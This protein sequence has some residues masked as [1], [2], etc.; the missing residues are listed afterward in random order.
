MDHRRGR[1]G[2]AAYEAIA[3][4]TVKSAQ[5]AVVEQLARGRR[6]RR[7]TAADHPPGQVLRAGRPTARDRHEPPVVHPQRRAAVRGRRRRPARRRCCAGPRSSTG[8]RRTCGPLRELGRGPQRRLARVAPTL[9]RRAVP[10]LVP[11]RRPTARST[12]TTRSCADESSCPSIRRPPRRPASTRPARPARR[13]RRRPRHHGH[14]GHLVADPADRHRLGRGRRPVRQDLPDGPAP[15][16]PRHH[17]HVAV[18]HRAALALE[19]DS[20]PW[21]NAALSGWI[22]DPDRKKMSKSKGN[23]VTPGAPHRAVRRRRRAL[24]GRQ[25]SAGHRHRV[26]RGPDE[27]RPAPGHQDPQRVEVRAQPRRRGRRRRRRAPLDPSPSPSRSTSRCSPGWPPSS[28]RPPP[29]STATTTPGRSSA[30]SPSS[31][32]SATTTSSS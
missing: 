8:T 32:A 29:P 4:K 16:G 24:L 13:L 9:L 28:T 11:G 17:P 2:R 27:G 21:T 18:L 1:R 26:R 6:P 25:R 23:V 10:G 12:T 14:L 31:G 19:H 5:A 30:P 7:R 22:L 20:L 3:G 15:P